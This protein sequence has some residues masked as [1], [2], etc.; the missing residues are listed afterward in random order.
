MDN[1]FRC[2][3]RKKN[4]NYLPL[5]D[6]ASELFPRSQNFS[7]FHFQWF[8]LKYRQASSKV[9]FKQ[10][11]LFLLSV[12]K[13]QNIFACL[14]KLG[15]K[16]SLKQNKQIFEEQKIFFGHPIKDRVQSEITHNRSKQLRINL[17][18]NQRRKEMI[19][20][21]QWKCQTFNLTLMYVFRC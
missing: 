15:R 4:I 5:I 3:T 14:W 2:S 20:I 21:Y 11:F 6:A 7:Y 13:C 18:I 1:S 17:K 9:S 10:G 8:C 12:W 16:K 19:G